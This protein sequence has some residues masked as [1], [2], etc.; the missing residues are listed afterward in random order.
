[1]SMISKE[2][3]CR[4]HKIRFNAESDAGVM[5]AVALRPIQKGERLCFSN[6]GPC[7]VH[8]L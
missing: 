8:R 4:K 7:H 3:F 2:R 6:R 5:M 1:M